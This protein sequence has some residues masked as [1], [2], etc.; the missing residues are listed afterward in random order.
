MRELWD[1]KP[2]NILSTVKWFRFN[3]IEFRLEFCVILLQFI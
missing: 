2:N 3:S 1:E